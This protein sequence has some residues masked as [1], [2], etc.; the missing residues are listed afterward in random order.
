MKQR[1]AGGQARRVAHTKC[2]S[3]PPAH[4]EG[5]DARGTTP[6]MEEVEPRL[7]QRP[8]ATQEQLP[9]VPSENPVGPTRTLAQRG[10][11]IRVA[12]LFFWL[13]FFGEA[14]R[15]RS[16]A[17]AAGGPEGAEGRMPGVKKSDSN[18]EGGRNRA[19]SLS[20]QTNCELASRPVI[21]NRNSRR[22]PITPRSRLPTLLHG[23]DT[24]YRKRVRE[25]GP[26]PTERY[27]QS[28]P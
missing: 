13:L 19:R 2:A 12:F 11:F 23:A 10:R 22:E 28:H 16:G 5:M 15:R 14:L 9:N 1:R 27:E 25:V 4:G 18:A 24:S 8:R 17:N 21:N 6:W 7:E 3:F 20:P 26:D